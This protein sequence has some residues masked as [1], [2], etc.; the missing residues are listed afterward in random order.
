MDIKMQRKKIKL[1]CRP[2]SK[3]FTNKPFI[4]CGMYKIY[5][6]LAHRKLNLLVCWNLYLCVSYLSIYMGRELSLHTYFRKELTWFYYAMSTLGLVGN[7]LDVLVLG[8]NWNVIFSYYNFVT[9]AVLIATVL[10]FNFEKIKLKL[11]FSITLYA[12]YINLIGSNLTDIILGQEYVQYLL[13]ETIFVCFLVTA[14]FIFVDR[15]HG[16]AIGISYSCYFTFS[17][18][19]SRDKFLLANLFDIL[20]IFVAYVI[21]MGFFHRFITKSLEEGRDNTELIKDQN[22]EL[23]AM[24]QELTAVNTELHETQR[25]ITAQHEELLTLSESVSVQNAVLEEKNNKLNEAIDQKNKL[26]S[27]IAHDLKAPISS[28]NLLTEMMLEKF[29]V[30][31]EEKKKLWLSKINSSNKSLYE[32]LE[33]LLAWSRS[34]TNMIEFAPE[35]ILLEETIDRICSIYRNFASTKSVQLVKN[36][37]RNVVFYADQMMIE[38]VLRNLVS[39]A[40]KYSYPN[41]K[42]IISAQV[43]DKGLNIKIEDKGVGIGQEQLLRLFNI[44]DSQ[45]MPGTAGEK[46]TGL[47][48]RVSKEFIEKHNGTIL[49]ESTPGQG[50]IFSLNLPLSN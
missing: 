1:C 46:G 15:K 2:N 18:I 49:V 27:I 19:V 25:Q 31:D 36:I 33:N 39:N 23:T 21:I 34:Q 44:H 10:L 4:I 5:S 30:M 35:K 26:F 3:F 50:T 6:I 9:I 43:I 24:N 38:T 48:L 45:I 16:L 20:A 28:T 47:G 22:E 14:A 12:I 42:V 7:I 11:A 17:A 41:A 8:Y 32:L 13:R 29:D 37:E 40:I